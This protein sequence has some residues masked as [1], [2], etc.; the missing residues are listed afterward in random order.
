MTGTIPLGISLDV[1][2]DQ[3]TAVWGVQGS[4]SN[5]MQT[6]DFS[7]DRLQQTEWAIIFNLSMED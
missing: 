6:T 1:P 2:Q 3:E 4:S 7:L 5:H